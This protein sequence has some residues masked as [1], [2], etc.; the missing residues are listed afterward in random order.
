VDLDYCNPT[1]GLRAET[2][3][4]EVSADGQG[5][6]ILHEGIIPIRE[7]EG[8]DGSRVPDRGR[9]VKFLSYLFLEFPI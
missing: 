1:V 9:N 2:A 8:A 7:S 4:N 3:G 5:E 6:V